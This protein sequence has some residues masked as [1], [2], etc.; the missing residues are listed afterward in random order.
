MAKSQVLQKL[1]LHVFST[2]PLRF[3]APLCSPRV[4]L[5]QCAPLLRPRRAF[6][7]CLCSGFEQAPAFLEA[8]RFSLPV[9]SHETPFRKA[10]HRALP[11]D[12][13]TPPRIAHGQHRA[14]AVI[15]DP[16]AR[17]SS[18]ATSATR[19]ESRNSATAFCA[20]PRAA[21]DR[22]NSKRCASISWSI[23]SFFAAS[24]SSTSCKR[25]SASRTSCSS[26]ATLSSASAWIIFIR[27][28]AISRSPS[29]HFRS[30]TSCSEISANLANWS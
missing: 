7:P 26:S 4:A 17:A 14:Q 8:V 5:C 27:K 22:S 18:S 15:E 9:P 6:R 29:R 21:F 25:F 23:S 11:D 1:R 3:A 19:V 30:S 28:S 16:Y 10:R 12:F 2:S 20:S 13:S 24:R